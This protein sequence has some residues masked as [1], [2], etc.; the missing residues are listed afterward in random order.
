MQNLPVKIPDHLES[1]YGRFCTINAMPVQQIIDQHD[2]HQVLSRSLGRVARQ[3]HLFSESMRMQPL[4]LRALMVLL[5][6]NC[7]ITC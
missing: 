4:V 2:R 3:L 1:A 7:G 5:L 6:T